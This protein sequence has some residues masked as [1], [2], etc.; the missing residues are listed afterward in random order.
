[1]PR[2]RR[3]QVAGGRYHV[4]M[5]GNNRGEIF[6]TD[7]DRT[8]L[9]HAIGRAKRRHGWKVHAYCLM[10]N[11]YHLLIETPNRTLP[12]GCSGSTAP[13]LIAST[14]STNGSDICSSGG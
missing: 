5:R 2:R 14:R 8:M 3:P 12:S 11:H 4:T 10:S 13:T 1:M 9:I 7:E 6:A